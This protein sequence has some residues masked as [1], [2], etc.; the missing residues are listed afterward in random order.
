MKTAVD[1]FRSRVSR[2]EIQGTRHLLCGLPTGR[3]DERNPTVGRQRGPST[4]SPSP[5]TRFNDP[6]PKCYCDSLLFFVIRFSFCIIVRPTQTRPNVRQRI[7]RSSIEW[8]F[9]VHCLELRGVFRLIFYTVRLQ[10]PPALSTP[11][12]IVTI[13]TLGR[14]SSVILIFPPRLCVRHSVIVC[15]TRG[16]KYRTQLI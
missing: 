6:P 15:L 4:P 12:G 8:L 2:G 13:S 7:Q 3:T 14:T 5:R 16:S 10:G 9:G 11:H 1:P